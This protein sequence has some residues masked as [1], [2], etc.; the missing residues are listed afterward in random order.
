MLQ[1]VRRIFDLI[2]ERLFKCSQLIA[3]QSACTV[4]QCVARLHV[5]D[6]R[7]AAASGSCLLGWEYARKSTNASGGLSRVPM[8][9]S[10]RI[11]GLCQGPPQACDP[12]SELPQYCTAYNRWKKMQ[13]DYI[14]VRAQ[15]SWGTRNIAMAPVIRPLLRSKFWPVPLG[16]LDPAY[17]EDVDEPYRARRLSY[18]GWWLLG[19]G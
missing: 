1:A 17:G 15:D 2:S 10:E 11:A 12:F 19:D 14:L 13:K 7:K 18:S 5:Q 3:G 4:L 9:V 8:K 6:L 16:T